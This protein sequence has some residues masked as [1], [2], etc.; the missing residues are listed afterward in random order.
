MRHRLNRAR[1]HRNSPENLTLPTISG[2]GRF[3]GGRAVRNGW[4]WPMFFRLLAPARTPKRRAPLE[5]ETGEDNAYK[6]REP[7]SF[8]LRSRGAATNRNS[9][10]EVHLERRLLRDPAALMSLGS[11]RHHRKSRSQARVP[12]SA[13]AGKRNRHAAG[14]DVVGT[15]RDL[16]QFEVSPKVRPQKP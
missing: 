12:P 11:R 16:D 15:N 5:L 6:Q 10:E 9:L 2:K 3:L 4:G 8:T 14:D 1:F 13:A 7:L